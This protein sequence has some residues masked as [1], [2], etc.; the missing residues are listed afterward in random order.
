[1]RR[2]VATTAALVLLAAGIAP[3]ASAKPFMVKP[4]NPFYP[5]IEAFGEGSVEAGATVRGCTVQPLTSCPRAEL[6]GAKLPQALLR[7]LPTCAA[8]GAPRATL[9]G[10]DRLL[11]PTC[12]GADLRGIER[13]GLRRQLRAPRPRRP[14]SGRAHPRR[15]GRD[16]GAGADLSGANLF[17][18][19][20]SGA[21]LRG[22][23]PA[24]R[25]PD[26]GAGGGGRP[27]R[28]RPARRLALRGRPAP[29]GPAR[30]QARRRELLQHDHAQRHGAQ[31]ARPLPDS[32]CRSCTGRRS[33]SRPR[34]PSTRC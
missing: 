29:G 12:S 9:G 25:Q 18:A 22:A 30:G 14:L 17:S 24:R 21:N 1:M 31:Q 13:P 4:S 2:L 7:R 16:A 23:E 8:C 34:L 5:V 33:R 11:R 20:A 6:G 15:P 27:A 19:D 26:R 3:G 28:R 10:V 32:P